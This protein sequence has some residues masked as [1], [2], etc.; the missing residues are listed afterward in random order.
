MAKGT[1]IRA[2]T[3]VGMEFQGLT[4]SPTIALGGGTAAAAP[5]TGTAG[6][7]AVLTADNDAGQT[8]TQAAREALQRLN[9]VL[10][11]NS[12]PLKKTIASL[13]AFADALGRNSDKVDGILAGLERMTAPAAPPPV[14]YDLLAPE[15]FPPIDKQPSVQLAVPQASADAAHDTQRIL[16]Q[17]DT[18]EVPGFAGSQWSDSLPDLFQARIIEGFENAGYLHV[19]RPEGLTADDQLLIDIHRF[20]IS[21]GAAPQAEA[22]FTAKILGSDGR[23]VDAR[24]FEATAPVKGTDAVA[25][26][27]ALN[28]AFGKAAKDLILWTL[29]AL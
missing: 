22:A 24:A 6:E 4:G 27:A 23:I 21:S 3:H 19:G 18:G 25:A 10:D 1:P 15:G 28:E 14:S 13:E 17:A 16:I 29:T 8:M 26:V 11:E 5:V 2:D 12:A 9:K 7:P 20:R